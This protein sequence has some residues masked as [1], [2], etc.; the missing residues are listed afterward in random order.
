MNLRWKLLGMIV[1][2]CG[3]SLV[4]AAVLSVRTAAQAGSALLAPTHRLTVVKV[5]AGSGSVRDYQADR[6]QGVIIDCGLTCQA[7]IT[8]DVGISL[9]AAAELGSVFTGWSGPCQGGGICGLT[10]DADKVVTAT[11]VL[12]NPVLTVNKS[13][14]GTGAV[15]STPAGIMCG[16]QC[17]GSFDSAQLITLSAAAED[18]STFTGWSGACSGHQLCVLTLNVNR[19]V[20]A[21]FALHPQPAIAVS[22]TAVAGS[23]VHFTAE[24]GMSN[25]YACTWSFGDGATAPCEA[26][27]VPDGAGEATALTVTA[28]HTY[29][30]AGYYTVGVTATNAAGLVAP[31]L[32]LPVVPAQGAEAAQLYLPYLQ[33]QATTQ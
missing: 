25:Y 6:P 15:V 8:A 11:F 12:A 1:V 7:D 31:A 16:A 19:S 26:P 33:R 21:G 5:G 9:S 29:T 18:G 2:G 17:S 14:A 13:G 4:L 27:A 32:Q 22:G 30:D 3:M 24:L 28:S 10:M 20:T 23:V